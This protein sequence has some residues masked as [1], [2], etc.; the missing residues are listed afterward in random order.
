MVKFAIAALVA[1]L[2]AAMPAYAADSWTPA[3]KWTLSAEPASCT[4]S[5]AFR[6]GADQIRILFEANPPKKVFVLRIVSTTAKPEG[7]KVM[8]SAPGVPPQSGLLGLQGKLQNGAWL[9][10]GTFA[11]DALPGLLA[12]SDLSI[13]GA[14]MRWDIHLGGSAA[15]VGAISSCQE[16]LFRSWKIDPSELA[17]SVPAG[18]KEAV[19]W[20]T[21]DDYP[22]AALRAGQQGTVS[23]LWRIEPSGRA[24][25][26]R[27]IESSGW[28]LLDEVSCRIV[29]RR[30]HYL[31]AV[32]RNGRP[33]PA[34]DRATFRWVLP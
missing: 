17:N 22:K 11:R 6:S 19:T 26:C 21:S 7:G 12:A 32:D 5:R 8:I 25:D 2:G 14:G 15:V 27:V 30:G 24:E 10:S 33:A 4:M 1:G 28:P 13:E 18:S 34:W 31:P 9:S 23:L 29:T 20:I 16:N 3:G